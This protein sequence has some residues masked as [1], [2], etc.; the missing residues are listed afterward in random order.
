MARVEAAA[1]SGAS[2]TLVGA[3]AGGGT[4]TL[5][6]GRIHEDA[7]AG[8]AALQAAGVEPGDHVALL[9]PTSR[10][11]VTAVQAVWLAGA[12]VIC[13]P[14]PMRLGSIEEFVA[15]TRARIRHADATL[16]LLDAELEAFLT[17]EPGDPPTR[18]LDELTGRARDWERPPDDPD[19]LA[20]LQFTSGSTADP[21]GVMLPHRCVVQNIDAIVEGAGL[22]ADDRGVSWLPLY[23]DMGLIGLLMTP[24]LTGFDLVLGTPTD[25]LAAPADW[26]RWM[27]DYRGTVTCAP[28]FG[29]TLAARAMRRLDDLDLSAWRLGLNGAEPID[30]ES[31]ERFLAA[32]SRHGLDAKS[33]FCVYGMAEAALAISFPTPGTGMTVDT[34]DR[35]TLERGGYAAPRPGPA[36]GRWPGSAVRCGDSRS[37]SAT[38]APGRP[39]AT[40]R[41]ASSSCG[42]RR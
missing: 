6:W 17:P 20:L 9:G 10:A 24:M 21:K 14:L 31:V 11:F 22:G 33:A 3:A 29:Y 28:N 40:G 35:D 39:G 32:G 41:S 42:A 2:L 18:R 38:R 25:F 34:V 1:A 23:H 8:A 12:T 4:E 19:A 5:P 15:Q 27:S 37:G 7:Q 13:L 30:P 36:P 26:L 16:V